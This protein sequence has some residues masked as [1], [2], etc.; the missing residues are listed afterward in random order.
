MVKGMGHYILN[1]DQEP[2]EVE[3]IIDWAHWMSTHERRVM[4]TKFEST[5]KNDKEILIST[6]FLGVDHNFGNGPPILWETMIFPDDK[7]RYQRRHTSRYEAVIA[8]EEAQAFVEKTLKERKA[9]APSG[10]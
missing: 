2:V 1:K 6:V 7:W 8:H 3:N 10:E 5:D 4:L 9:D